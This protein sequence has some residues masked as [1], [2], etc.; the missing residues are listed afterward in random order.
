MSIRDL[1]EQLRKDRQ[2]EVQAQAADPA[3]RKDN[4]AGNPPRGASDT[5]RGASDTQVDLR[6]TTV[7]MPAPP[8]RARPASDSTHPQ[9]AEP[10]A[11]ERTINQ[12]RAS[13]L[14]KL[15]EQLKPDEINRLPEDLRRIDLRLRIDKLLD[16]EPELLNYVQRHQLIE[17]L[18]DDMLGLGPLEKLLRDPSVGDILINGASEVYVERRGLLEKAPLTFRDNDHL[19]EIIQRIVGRV[20]RRVN[21]ASPLVDARLADG[22]RVNAIIPPLSL[23]GPLVSIRRFGV[24]PLK[25]AD[26][27]AY[28][29][30][31]PEMAQFLEA[32]V[33]A[34][35]SMVISGGT[36]SGK[37]TL[38]NVLSGYI[39]RHERII[40]IEDAAEL[41]L[42][43]DHVATLETRPANL[44]GKGEITIRDLVRNSLRMR[45]DRIIIGECRGAEALDMLQAMNTG[46]EGSMTTIH[47]NSPR[48]ALGR[49]EIMI[50]MTGLDLPLRAM[51]QQLATALNLIVQVD[52]VSGGLRRV[53]SITEI[54][55]M[56]GDTITL[57]ELFAY[58]QLGVD[59]TGKALGRFVATGVHSHYDRRIAAK[60]IALPHDLYAPRVLLAG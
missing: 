51:R 31:A 20:G 44:E 40:T 10:H 15:M 16:A 23:K 19:M 3:E 8:A 35:L 53:S 6:L 25:M 45:P 14:A 22:S 17:D 4:G 1:F 48:D 55:G 36:G 34:R 60:G 59:A 32:A 11:D 9:P 24:R 42:Q 58:E 38:L 37:T 47:A 12:L 26:L 41:Q 7:A 43:Q 13:L 50:M 21:E 30:L 39:P 29:T 27:L 56:E 49:L 28:H 5:Q 52:R 18:L 57:Q 46:H 2:R 54:V 33:K